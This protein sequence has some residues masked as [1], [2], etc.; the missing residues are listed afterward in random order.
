MSESQ[1]DGT[2]PRPQLRRSAWHCLDGIWAFAFDPADRGRRDKWF[3]AEAAQFFDQT[4][5]VPYPPESTASGI[6]D[7]GPHRV[8]WYRRTLSIAELDSLECPETGRF[9]LHFGAVDYE[10]DV[11]V[12]GQ[13]LARHVGGQ[14]PFTIDIT[15]ALDEN[16]DEHAI[17]VRAQDDPADTSQPRGKQTWLDEP[18]KVW[19]DRT[20]GIWQTVWLEAVPELHITEL[21]WRA[22]PDEGISATVETAGPTDS[23]AT[24]TITVSLGQRTLGH[25]AAT[26]TG[27]RTELAIPL[28]EM[29]NGIDREDLLWAPE[30]PVLLDAVVTISG[31][32]G[33]RDSAVSYL[34]LRQTGVGG[35]KY[36]LNGRPY[37]FRG[38]LNQGYRPDTMLA[39][40]GTDEL[41]A[42]IELAKAMGFNAMRIHQKAEDPRI[43][44]WA[45]RLGMLIWSEI[46][47]AYE[48]TSTA[49]QRL[50][51]EWTALVRRDRSHPSVVAWVP[52]NES[53]GVP[54]LRTVSAQRSFISAIAALTRA[55]DPS[56][57]VMSNEGWEHVDSDVLGVHDYTS[58]PLDLTAR[59]GDAVTFSARLRQPS[60]AAA[61]RVIALSDAQRDKFDAGDAPLIISEFGGLSLR[62]GADA[63]A[64]TH[65]GSDTELAA[66]LGDLFSALRSSSA[67]AGFCYTQLFDTAQETNGLA[68]E[69]GRPKLALETIRYIVTG[70]KDPD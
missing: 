3:S 66:R 50:T 42:E 65:V 67:V 23:G 61:G 15:D 10:A 17:V 16:A 68:D 48:F 20:S 62:S 21:L 6:G 53:W 54:N 2:Y 29:A 47:A 14:S 45:D 41:R 70:E 9:L 44:Y 25:A 43:L 34:G 59:Y 18:S 57:P 4:I 7:R 35:G 28:R 19:Y 69:Q 24:V 32:N 38:V 27:P 1:H 51:E 64:Y 37:F 5:V 46:G 63:F 12:G 11:W 13:H 26:L 49:L 36:L 58:N 30:H 40:R 56:R 60:D 39:N 33:A 55:L 31:G 22:D 8:L 52:I